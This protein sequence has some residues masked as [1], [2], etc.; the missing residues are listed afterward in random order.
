MG[1]GPATAGIVA[2]LDRIGV[3][4]DAVGDGDHGG[5]VAADR[6][7]DQ[8]GGGGGAGQGRGIGGIGHD[9][10]DDLLTLRR[11]NRELAHPRDELGR[12]QGDDRTIGDQAARQLRGLIGRALADGRLDRLGVGEA[13]GLDGLGVAQEGDVDGGGLGHA[14]VQADRR[15][16]RR[17]GGR[18]L[19]L[20]LGAVGEED[21]GGDGGE[22]QAAA[23]GS[24]GHE[25]YIPEERETAKG[26]WPP[27]L[28]GL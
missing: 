18:R 2:L 11:I 19:R 27:E 22:R 15:R 23:G 5:G 20:R 24:L 6:C 26:A 3:V 14:F 4:F 12:L 10:G 9:L 28:K 13:A 1:G 25:R 8:A 17:R 7:G 16:R 21:G